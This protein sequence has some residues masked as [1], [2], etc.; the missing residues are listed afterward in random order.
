[1]YYI[2]LENENCDKIIHYCRNCGNSDDNLVD[3]NKCILKENINKQENKFNIN[4]NKYT[5]LDNTLPRINYIKCPNES[6]VSNGHDFDIDIREII[7]IRY[8]N[9]SMRYLY[10]CSHCDYVWKTNK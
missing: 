5:K 10:L 8:D 2:K 1:M 6:C 7:Y 3:V 4:V 9:I